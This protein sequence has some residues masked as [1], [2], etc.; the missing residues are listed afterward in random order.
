[1]SDPTVLSGYIC[2]ALPTYQT[3]ND[4]FR[5][6]NDT[7]IASLPAVDTW[8]PPCL[9]LFATTGVDSLHGSFRGRR[10]IHFAAHLNDFLE[11]TDEWLVKFDA[12]MRRLDWLDAELF[13]RSGCSG[14]PPEL[15]C[16]VTKETILQV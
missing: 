15:R 2:E 9:N 6:A 14:T 13:T 12:L 3:D 16:R 11:G 4:F 1:M 8:P 10:I 7:V 5:T